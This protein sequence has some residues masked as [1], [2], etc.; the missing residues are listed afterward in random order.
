MAKIELDQTPGHLD[1]E[2]TVG[3]SFASDVSQ[4]SF[5]VNGPQPTISEY[6]AYDQNDP[7]NPFLAVTQD[8][9]GNVVYDGGFPKL[10]NN[11][12]PDGGVSSFDDLPG[13][14][15]YI[16]NAVDFVANPDKVN[17]GNKTA[18]V[19][20]DRDSSQDKYVITDSVGNG[21]Y[22]SLEAI[23]AVA[24]YT[25]DYK[26]S[27]DYPG[28]ELDPSLAEL[29]DY[30]LVIYMS[31]DSGPGPAKLTDNAVTNLVSFRENGNGLIVIT[32]H[33]PEVDTIDDALVEEGFIKGA[34]KLV[35]NFGVFFSGD[36]DRDN[37]EVGFLRSEYG[38][39]P[40]YDNLNDSDEIFGG[41]SES[42]VV[43]ADIT[44]YDPSE[45]PDLELADDG[46]YVI[47]TLASMSDGSTEAQRYL[48]TTGN[49]IGPVLTQHDMV[50]CPSDWTS[51]KQH[52][53]LRVAVRESGLGGLEG[54]LDH[55]GSQVATLSVE[56]DDGSITWDGGSPPPFADGDTLTLVIT[57]PFRYERAITLNQATLTNPSPK[58]LA[59]LISALQTG[60][61]DN[62]S[63]QA[64]LP[65]WRAFLDDVETV[66]S[67]YRTAALARRIRDY[68]TA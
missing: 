20:G 68:L 13:G 23:A 8:G 2:A 54:Y 52:L 35:V 65:H 36:V 59:A 16:H 58:S 49:G 55:N 43:V 15:K 5:S 45:A 11:R 63:P 9:R 44:T 24:G 62:V 41:G 7:P 57:T 64:M 28:G 56:D 32:D 46:V 30:A 50:D 27:D 19:L 12:L 4:M 37:V 29:E 33:G 14:H 31:T 17:N 67:G 66:P 47:N 10:Y 38:D 42:T 1:G 60:D 22:D 53:D 6:I 21:F 25:F 51:L 39:H 48:V 40:L 61:T 3:W 26:L 18:L 34:N